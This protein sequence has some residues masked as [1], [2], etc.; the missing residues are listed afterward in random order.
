MLRDLTADIVTLV[1]LGLCMLGI[2]FALPPAMG[3]EV[4][5][6]MV[7]GVRGVI[8]MQS[9]YISLILAIVA[10]ATAFVKMRTKGMT[11]TQKTD[12]ESKSEGSQSVADETHCDWKH[13]KIEDSLRREFTSEL[14]HVREIID[15]LR[16]DV[17]RAF[18]SL[19]NI[20]QRRN[21][22]QTK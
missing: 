11:A 6:T 1:V 5:P 13:Q 16:R 20:I 7:A 12:K 14:T 19:D 10:L 2:F 8:T 21:G 22:Q 15:I 17:D 9:I 4:M 3:H 18:K